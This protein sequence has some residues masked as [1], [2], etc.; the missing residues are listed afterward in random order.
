[1]AEITLAVNGM[2]WRCFMSLPPLRMGLSRGLRCVLFGVLLFIGQ[3]HRLTAQEIE[4]DPSRRYRML[5]LTDSATVIKRMN[6]VASDGYRVRGLVPDPGA[7]AQGAWDN[8]LKKSAGAVVL[9][10][11]VG[12]PLENFQYKQIVGGGGNELE[13]RLNEAG[14]AGFRLLSR[15]VAL[16]WAVPAQFNVLWMEKDPGP[17]KHYEYRVIDMGMKMLLGAG[18]KPKYWFETNAIQYVRPKLD[19]YYVEGFRIVLVIAGSI[20]V[21]E[22]SLDDVAEPEAP[23]GAS[24]Q[25]A[26]KAP[27]YRS[28]R[29]S[30]PQ[31]LD[32]QLKKAATNGYRMVD[33]DATPPPLEPAVI[34]EKTANAAE[35]PAYVAVEG[36]GLAATEKLMSDAGNRGFRLLPRSVRFGGQEWSIYRLPPNEKTGIR[37]V[38]AKPAGVTATYEYRLLA[39]ERPDEMFSQLRKLVAEGYRLAG[40]LSAQFLVMERVHEGGKEVAQ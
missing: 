13:P 4:V 34:L 25:K 24:P 3:A 20:A 1:M 19:S 27:R 32:E 6:D 36:K 17:A 23:S 22:K 12:S 5:R 21:M 7:A 10:E 33:L 30:K 37:A 18:M 38:L 29:Y 40:L 35:I 39:H 26:D 8:H 14:S 15:D 2:P 16:A 9:L 11:K 28:L 31:K